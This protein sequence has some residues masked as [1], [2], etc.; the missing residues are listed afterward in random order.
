LRDPFV[1]KSKIDRLCKEN[2]TRLPRHGPGKK[3]F[4]IAGSDDIGDLGISRQIPTRRIH[5]AAGELRKYVGLTFSPPPGA[6]EQKAKKQAFEIKIHWRKSV[7]FRTVGKDTPI[8]PKGKASP[9]TPI[10]LSQLHHFQ[11]F[12]TPA[13]LII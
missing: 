10:P 8:F 5:R 4:R 7:L 3:Q 11:S 13:W 9:I 2:S 6:N 1:T 12:G